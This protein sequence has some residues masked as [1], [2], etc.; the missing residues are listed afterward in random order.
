MIPSDLHIRKESLNPGQS[1]IVEA[2][3]GSGKTTILIQRYLKLL[4]GVSQPEEILA[5][6]FT[7][8][9]AGEMKRRIIE[10]L[11]QTQDV[12]PP[13]DEP[14]KTTWNLA[15]VALE[16]NKKFGWRLLENPARLRVVTIDS[17]CSFLTK[18]TPL[19]SKMGGPTEIQE[20]IQDL[21]ANTAKQILS[22]IESADYQYAEL[23][24]VLLEHLDNDKKT[25]IQ[26]ISQLLNLRDQWMIS[27]FDKFENIKEHLLDISYKEKLEK[28][29]TELIEKE[30]IKF[31]RYFP[32]PHK[33]H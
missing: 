33:P 20:N 31:I 13:E 30:L 16:R 26:R 29:Y 25:F 5:M 27:F 23:V 19:L 4:G 14:D 21:Y 18:R 22:K 24:R 3:A 2:P 17:F 11:N 8:K 10:A 28:L 12:S 6:T 7:R 1:F 15:Q 32:N 9:A